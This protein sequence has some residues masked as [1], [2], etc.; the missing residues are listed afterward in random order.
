MSLGDVGHSGYLLSMKP[1][2]LLEGLFEKKKWL[3][4]QRVENTLNGYEKATSNLKLCLTNTQS[5][6]PESDALV[7][8][9]NYY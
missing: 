7:S 4:P 2:C 6:G 3:A 9:T 1:I 8:E 5:F